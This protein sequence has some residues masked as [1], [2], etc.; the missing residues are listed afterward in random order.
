MKL[1]ETDRNITKYDGL[2]RLFI[3]YVSEGITAIIKQ[4][5]CYPNM[6][7]FSSCGDDRFKREWQALRHYWQI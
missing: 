3:A 5:M 1:S 2:L 4:L 6:L 7:I